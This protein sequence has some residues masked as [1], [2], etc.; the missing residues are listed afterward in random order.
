MPDIFTLLLVIQQMIDGLGRLITIAKQ[1]GATDEQ[2]DFL[3]A[4]LTAAIERRKGT[5]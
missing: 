3:D 4:S 5:A 2:L 1:M